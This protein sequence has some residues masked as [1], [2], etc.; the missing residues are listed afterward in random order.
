MRDEVDAEERV[1]VLK[2][3]AASL[4]GLL[5]S[6]RS[7]GWN[8]GGCVGVGSYIAPSKKRATGSE[9]DHSINE[10]A[11]EVKGE[12]KIKR[13]ELPVSASRI[14]RTTLPMY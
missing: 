7:R 14:S 12:A 2:V 4:R 6:R 5:A 13:K 8:G 11:V 9:W 3:D 1:R 10:L